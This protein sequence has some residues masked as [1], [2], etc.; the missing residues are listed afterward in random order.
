MLETRDRK[1]PHPCLV[2]N[3]TT[4]NPRFCSR[5]CSAKHTNTINPKRKLTKQC[6]GCNNIVRYNRNYCK[7]CRPHTQNKD[8]TLGEAIYTKHHVSSAYCLVR[9]RA[10]MIAKKLGWK[11]C[12]NCGYSKHIEIAHIKAIGDFPKETLLSVINDPTNLAPLCP[13]CHWEF[14]N[15]VPSLRVE[16]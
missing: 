9:T 4:T 10:R 13:N 1:P 15:L 16:L 8:M 6:K 14:D 12:K 2:C 7:I 5:S 3:N 11:S